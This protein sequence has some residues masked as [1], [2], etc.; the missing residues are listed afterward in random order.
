MTRWK[1]SKV[2]DKWLA[3]NASTFDILTIKKK[4]EEKIKM[5]GH[6]ESYTSFEEWLE[7]LEDNYDEMET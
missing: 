2:Y 5:F 4:M 7:E 3:H 6:F 1:L